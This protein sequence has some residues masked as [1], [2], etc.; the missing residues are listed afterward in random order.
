MPTWAKS[1][2]FIRNWAKLSDEEK[3][4]FI[5]AVRQF[6]EDLPTGRFRKGLRI[7]GYQRQPGVFE[8]TW[9]D[10]G[11]ALWQYGDE[12]RPGEPHIEWLAVGGHDIF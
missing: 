7:R 10:N 4:Q 6:R 5:D 9:A 2:E 11:R 8:M 12:V 3:A 1:P